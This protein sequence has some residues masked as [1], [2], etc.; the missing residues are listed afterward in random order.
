[1]EHEFNCNY[2]RGAGLLLMVSNPFFFCHVC[3]NTLAS[4][5]VPV[6]ADMWDM[7][8]VK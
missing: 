5:E 2:L 1:M 4:L 7:H 8:F 6:R 3:F